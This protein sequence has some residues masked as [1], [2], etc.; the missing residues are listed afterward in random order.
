MRNPG[1]TLTMTLALALAVAAPLSVEAQATATKLVRL[2]DVSGGSVQ[3]PEALFPEFRLRAQFSMLEPNGAIV[4][5]DIE[6][7][8]LKFVNQVFAGTAGKL[9]GDWSV[10]LLVDTSQTMASGNG[11]ADFKKATDALSKQIDRAGDSAFLS[12]ITFDDSP[13]IVQDLAKDREELKKKLT[14]GIFAKGSGKSCLNQG[15]FEAVRRVKDLPT[16]RAVFVLTASQDTCETPSAQSVIDLARQN[17]VQIYA[18]G[19]DGYTISKAALER[20]TEP[21]GGLALMTNAGEAII[22]IGNQMSLLANQWETAYAFFPAKGAQTAEMNLTL[23]DGSLVSRTLS[24][25]VDRDYFPPPKIALKGEVQTLSAGL[26]F[27]LDITTKDKIKRVET[28]VTNKRTAAEVYRESLTD[29]A[30]SNT[31]KPAKLENGLEYILTVIAF[32]DQNRPISTD[33]REFAFKPPEFVLA[34]ER[35]E[36]PTFVGTGPAA[37]SFSVTVRA[38]NPQAVTRYQLYLENTNANNAV[39]V[40]SEVFLQSDSPL[41]IPTKDLAPGTYV[42]R[43]RA[44]ASDQALGGEAARS[45]PVAFAPPSGMDIFMRQARDN[46]ILL[47]GLLG[48]VLLAVVVLVTVNLMA[49][50]RSLRAEK[51]VE[52][53]LPVNP[54]RSAPVSAEPQVAAV[55]QFAPPPPAGYPPPQSAYAAAPPAMPSAPPMSQQVRAGGQP[56]AILTL[57]NA[58]TGWEGRISQASYTVGRAA[59]NNGVLPVDGTSGVSSRHLLITHDQAGWHI[60][61]L[62]RNGTTINGQRIP[63]NQAV[64]LPN[65]VVLGLGPTIKV[66]FRSLS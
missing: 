5:Q 32:D 29:F 13:R 8:S 2:H 48:A 43:V 26:V 10:S 3:A 60:T 64:P 4:N 21:T 65:G 37:S 62:S 36:P 49:R 44:F 46:P 63:P 51:V 59:D 57:K 45:A 42:V 30:P 11:A 23:K 61:D 38:S 25:E 55:P 20:F 7:T 56:T 31:I 27:N 53:A 28:R 33:Q 22:T 9:T 16:R 18:V 47:I 15:L 34:I 54:R 50:N 41:L 66:E 35:V 6:K 58:A 17:K 39:I 24:F 40:A 14:T 1:K 19:L 12:L 52:A